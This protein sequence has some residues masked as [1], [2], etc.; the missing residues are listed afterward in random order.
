MRFPPARIKIDPLRCMGDWYV[1]CLV[2]A[3]NWLERTAYNGKENYTYDEKTGN[4]KVTYTFNK[5]SFD[6]PVV[7]T[8]Q[9]GRVRTNHKDSF[10]TSWAVRPYLGFLYIPFYIPFELPYHII[11][12]D[13]VHYSFITCSAPD[14]AWMY[15]M[16]RQQ[17][18]DDA[19]IAPMLAKL[20]AM[21]FDMAKVRKMQQRK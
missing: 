9:K 5:G 3:S 20:A 8:Y 11:D 2:P 15:V 16:T 12:I 7:T 18:V 13:P 17:T 6:G 1:Q 21:G 4:V 14:G 19:F 10:G